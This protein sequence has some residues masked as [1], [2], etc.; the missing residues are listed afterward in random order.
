MEINVVILHMISK[1]MSQQMRAVI[2][3]T[4]ASNNILGRGL[5]IVSF[6]RYWQSL[7]HRRLVYSICNVDFTH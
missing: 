2:E 4:D 1:I 3:A 6:C 5:S 7:N